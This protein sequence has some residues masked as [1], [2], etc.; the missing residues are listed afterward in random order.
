[1]SI[2]RIVITGRLTADPE[3]KMTPSNVA[4][5]TISV[6]V[7]RNYKNENG[8]HDVDYFDVVAWRGTAEFIAKY[9]R[10]GD[11]IEVDGKLRTR[12]WKDKYDQNRISYEIQADN[13]D[14]GGKKQNSDSEPEY[15]ATPVNTADFREVVDDDP[16]F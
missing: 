8:E 3:L 4:V 5:L 10:K 2:N 15:D 1:M 14:F 6:A 7:D 9:F 11:K 13:V 12:K 16:P